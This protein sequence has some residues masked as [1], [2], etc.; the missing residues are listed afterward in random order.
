MNNSTETHQKALG[1]YMGSTRPEHIWGVWPPPETDDASPSGAVQR[2]VVRAI[3]VDDQAMARRILL[4]EL[5]H[6]PDLEVVGEADSA[7][8]GVALAQEQRPDIVIMDLE[9]PVMDGV[10]AARRLHALAPDCLIMLL[11]TV[12]SAEAHDR[13]RAAGARVVLQKGSPAI[14][15]SAFHD[16]VQFVKAR[17]T[18][19]WPETSDVYELASG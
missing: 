3:V 5:R 10:Q 17:N 13:G 1:R 15:R 6:E 9:M 11:T 8:A 7:A 18:P 14:F 16:L 4:R 2:T 12:D 19:A